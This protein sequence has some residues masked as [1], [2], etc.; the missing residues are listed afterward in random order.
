MSLNQNLM[1]KNSITFHNEY[2][3]CD[4]CLQERNCVVETTVKHYPNGSCE[5][6]NARS[7]CKYCA[8]K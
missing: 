8:D 2:T 4:H 7:L 3:K 1:A 5:A 6:V